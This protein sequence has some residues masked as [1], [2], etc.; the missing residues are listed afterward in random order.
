[1]K[2]SKE[3]QSENYHILDFQEKYDIKIIIFGKDAMFGALPL[4]C[5]KLS[6]PA[7]NFP[8]RLFLSAKALN[9]LFGIKLYI[10]YIYLPHGLFIIW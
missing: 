6:M 7:L 5:W 3:I 2:E 9:I 8:S 1:M 4:I 10:K